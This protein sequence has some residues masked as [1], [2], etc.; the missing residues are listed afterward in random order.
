MHA[1]QHIERPTAVQD[2]ALVSSTKKAR[3]CAYQPLCHAM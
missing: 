1:A 2:W 3:R